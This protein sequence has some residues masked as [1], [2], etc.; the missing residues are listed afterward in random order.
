MILKKGDNAPYIGVLTPE[1]IYRAKEADLRAGKEFRNQFIECERNAL[2]ASESAESKKYWWI[3]LGMALIVGPIV[4]HKY[5]FA[6]DGS[7]AQGW[8]H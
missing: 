4:L 3:A 1:E 8:A 5:A 2:E 6:M 7:R